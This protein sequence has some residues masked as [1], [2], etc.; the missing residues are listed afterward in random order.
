[1]T[2]LKAFADDKINVAQMMISVFDRIE[3]IVGKGEITGYQQFFLLPQCFQKDSFLGSLKVVI[4][5]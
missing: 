4:V 1:M 2:K 3:N 5:W